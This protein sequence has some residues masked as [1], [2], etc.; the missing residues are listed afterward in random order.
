MT[1]T[2]A[3]KQKIASELANRIFV[4]AKVTGHSNGDQIM[5]AIQAIDNGME[6]T[7][8]Q[9]VAASGGTTKVK[10]AFLNQAKSGAPN[11]TNQEAGLALALWALNEV[12]L[13]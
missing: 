9:A 8:N 6:A 2:T 11:L 4:N 13:L 7:L 12:N 5:A 10:I 3:Q 1:V